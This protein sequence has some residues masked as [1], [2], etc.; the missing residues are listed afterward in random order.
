MDK[1]KRD[2]LLGLVFFVALALL[3]W[4]TKELSGFRLTPPQQVTI[5][6]A[7]ARGL[8][9]GEPVFVL[10]TQNGKVTDVRI[11]IEGAPFRVRATLELDQP[12]QF[13]DT[14]K[15]TIVDASFLGGK[16]VNI[17]PGAEGTLVDSDTK[18]FI[19]SAPLGPL[20][21]LGEL[22]SGDGN[23]EN[24]QETLAGFRKFMDTLNTSNGTVDKLIRDSKL[25]DDAT[26]TV[27]S[28]RRSAEEIEKKQ[29]LLGR[30]IHDDQLGQRADRVIEGL[31]RVTDQL[32][33][34]SSV[35]G[36][37]INDAALGEKLDTIAN[38]IAAVAA[39]LRGT[40]GALGKL[41]NDPAL[42]AKVDTVVD[43]IAKVVARLND[44]DAGLLGALLND[45]EL[46][47][48]GKQL[49]EDFAEVVAKVNHGDGALGRLINDEEMGRRLDSLLKQL[50]RAIEDAREA[51][52]I[53]TFFQVF[54][55]SF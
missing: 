21:S 29:G 49:V 36:K 13:R 5:D 8:R 14:A 1:G 52:P 40:K 53:G 20:D 22:V 9:A 37:L 32:T 51:A 3:L 27:E 47:S 25:Y 31:E 33:G 46:R 41:I 26:A 35:F 7:N 12:V 18:V 2:T 34:T 17:D 55:G 24:L 19:G 38:D 42:G 30:L 23:K 6:F 11:R 50:T 28:L 39:E 48:S 43:D 10:G 4:A 54:S 45:E 16:K 44:K 15:I